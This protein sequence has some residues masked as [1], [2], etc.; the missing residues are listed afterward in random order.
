MNIS[1]L[2]VVGPIMIGPSSSHTAGAAKL[3]KVALLIANRKFQKVE[4]GLG[5]S[6]AST[7]K[8]HFTDYALIA[9][10]LGFDEDDER[11]ANSV[12]IAKSEKM[13]YDFYPC[14]IESEYE[15]TVRITFLYDDHT[16]FYVEGASLGGG[17]ILITDINGLPCKM[18]ASSS[19]IIIKQHDQKGIIG[20]VA[21]ILASHKVNI[22]V[23]TVNRT[24]R[25]GLAFCVIECDEY[26][27][28]DVVEKL[29]EV[30]N[31]ISVVVVNI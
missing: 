19:T 16:T 20:E 4:F 11:L 30:D 14:D 25:G 24:I 23:M 17:R 5:G 2:E 18:N 7:Y 8:G 13:E 15:N 26:I 1:L 27:E 12:E 31:I 6:F 10:V 3:A 28:D 22:G 29:K 21:L 9:G